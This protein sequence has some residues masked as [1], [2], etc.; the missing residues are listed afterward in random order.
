LHQER[1][2]VGR[3]ITVDTD[4]VICPR[5]KHSFNCSVQFLDN[6][7]LLHAPL[8]QLRVAHDLSDNPIRALNL[9]LDD[10]DLLSGAVPAILQGALERKSRVVDYCQRVLNLMHE[11]SRHSSGGAQLPFAHCKLTRFFFGLALLY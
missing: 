9:L 5:W 6:V 1:R 10:P 3:E 7:E 4:G 2:K 11:L 8:A